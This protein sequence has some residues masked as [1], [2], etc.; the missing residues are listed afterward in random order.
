MKLLIVQPWFTAMG[1]PAQ[2]MLNTARAL[3]PSSDVGYLISDPGGAEF[4]AL[5]REL[6]KYGPTQ[7]FHS[8]GPSL[9]TGTLFSLPAV[10]RIARKNTDLLHVFFLDADLVCLAAAW[11]LVGMLAGRRRSISAVYLGGPDR[12]AGN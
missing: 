10:L 2:S 3:G 9:R 8:H 11:P 1:H 12:I 4:S 7:S 5:A 6:K